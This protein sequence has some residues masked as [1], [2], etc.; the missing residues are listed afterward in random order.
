MKDETMFEA[1]DRWHAERNDRLLIP[2]RTCGG[3]R[4]YVS[5]RTG[6]FRQFPNERLVCAKCGRIEVT[7]YCKTGI[8]PPRPKTITQLMSEHRDWDK[9]ARALMQR[10]SRAHDVPRWL[11]DE[12]RKLEKNG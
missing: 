2:C 8:R 9:N 5:Y 3:K 10:A 6:A 11:K 7:C 4:H 12:I 1:G